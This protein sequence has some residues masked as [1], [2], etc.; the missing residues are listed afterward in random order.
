MGNRIFPL[1]PSGAKAVFE[2]LRMFKGV[3]FVGRREENR[4]AGAGRQNGFNIG[5]MPMSVQFS[6]VDDVGIRAAP[7]A[8]T[9]LGQS[10]KGAW[11]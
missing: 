4:N 3:L 1:A 7:G 9:R 6:T 10:I 8:Q 5:T 11:A 2:L